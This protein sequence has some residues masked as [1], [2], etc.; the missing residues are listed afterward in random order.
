VNLTADGPWLLGL[1]LATTRIAA[2]IAIAPPLAGKTVPPLAKGGLAIAL[3][4]PVA[5]TM[6]QAL[7]GT[8]LTDLLPAMAGQVL[9]GLALGFIVYVLFSAVQAAGDL[10]DLF[11]GFT[12]AAAYDPLSQ[13]TSG[14]IG[15]LHS[16]IA[17][18]LLMVS[19]GQLLLLRGVVG[20]VK[21]IPLTGF[22]A[23]HLLGGT[24][25]QAVSRFM[26]AALQLAAPVIAVLFVT[27]VAMGIL[28][29]A[30]PALNVLQT[31]FPVKIGITFM[32]LTAA[33]P[34]IPDAVESQV[35]ASLGAMWHLVGQ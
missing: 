10:I 31:G 23:E 17:G 30:A 14:P 28:S 33:L 24:V 20:S 27:E 9:A 18:T 3:A 11:G 15:R 19:N 34:L 4:L 8:D 6:A 5:P 1:L 12:L 25:T 32:V 21:G 13:N 7:P 16:M 29:R 2:F 26:V 22:S 35:T